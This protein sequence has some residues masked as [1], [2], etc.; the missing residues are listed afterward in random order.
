VHWQ[1]HAS[2]GHSSRDGL[3]RLQALRPQRIDAALVVYGVNDVTRG[4]TQ[5]QF[6][7]RQR[8]IWSTLQA[9]FGTRRI[10][11]SGVPP[12]QHFPL[13]PQPLAWVLGRQAAR[14]D[15]GLARAAAQNPQV[16]HLPLVLPRRPEF[17]AADGFHPSPA[18]YRHWAEALAPQLMI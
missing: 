10:L 15:R 7:A 2:T 17:A 13:L 9:R 18:A 16:V 11:V 4:V 8:A 5:S 6:A 1:L 12:M 3:R 14:L